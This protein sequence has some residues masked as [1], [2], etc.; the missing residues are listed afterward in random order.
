MF[1]IFSSILFPHPTPPFL[2]CLTFAPITGNSQCSNSGHFLLCFSFSFLK[3]LLEPWSRERESYFFPDTFW[4]SGKCHG[5]KCKSEWDQTDLGSNF[6]KNN[7]KT[8]THKEKYSLLCLIRMV[9]K[10]ACQWWYRAYYRKSPPHGPHF[11]NL[12]GMGGGC[13]FPTHLP[14][15][16]H[17]PIYQ[18]N[19]L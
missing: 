18:F 1:L 11:A 12:F 15:V 13:V 16:L 4:K 19:F 9:G 7:P 17:H 3:M 10:R 8:H 14:Q 6:K 2:S 5:W